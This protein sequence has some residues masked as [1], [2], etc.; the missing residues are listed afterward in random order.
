M[1]IALA[2]LPFLFTTNQAAG[3]SVVLVGTFVVLIGVVPPIRRR[4]AARRVAN[5]RVSVSEI[6]RWLRDK[7]NYGTR[8]IQNARDVRTPE[9]VELIL[10]PRYRQW[11]DEVEAGVNRHCLDSDAQRIEYLD[12]W[13]PHTFA[14]NVSPDHAHIRDM[15]CETVLRLRDLAQRLERGETRLK[16]S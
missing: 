16:R 1:T 6:V 9:D 11:S 8:E 13:D 2:G 15:T 7:A 10:R 4:I 12:A 5:P 3:L 14:G